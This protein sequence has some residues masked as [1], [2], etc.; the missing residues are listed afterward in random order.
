M[1]KHTQICANKPRDARMHTHKHTE[2]KPSKY[3]FHIGYAAFPIFDQFTLQKKHINIILLYK[4]YMY[5]SMLI[6]HNFHC[7]F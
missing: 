4:N 7:T 5:I 6:M 3:I 2:S 1:H